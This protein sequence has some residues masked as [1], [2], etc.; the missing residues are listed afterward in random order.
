MLFNSLN[1]DCTNY[2]QDKKNQYYQE[3]QLKAQQA[4]IIEQQRNNM[5]QQEMIR[6]QQIRNYLER[7]H[8]LLYVTT[9][10]LYAFKVY[11]VLAKK[12]FFDLIYMYEFN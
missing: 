5:L 7:Q 11:L 2:V 4:L 12:I 9:L 6:E 1:Q 10:L 8:F 3:E